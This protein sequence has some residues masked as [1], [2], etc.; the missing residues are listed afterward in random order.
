MLLWNYSAAWEVGGSHKHFIVSCFFPC[1]FSSSAI[2]GFICSACSYPLHLRDQKNIH[3]LAQ[4]FLRL[5]LLL[6]PGCWEKR[7][8]LQEKHISVYG[9][10]EF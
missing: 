1:I 8:G 3:L 2:H 7:E 10:V 5:S 6:Q 9:M 4:I